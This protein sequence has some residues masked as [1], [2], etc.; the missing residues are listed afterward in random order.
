MIRIISL[1]HH[2]QL[3]GQT[4]IWNIWPVSRDTLA[5]VADPAGR[6]AVEACDVHISGGIG[7]VL[8]PRI[9]GLTTG[10][11]REEY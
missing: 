2:M 10:A 5:N 3:R 9:R 1:E 7:K 8:R 11:R 6:V 4:H